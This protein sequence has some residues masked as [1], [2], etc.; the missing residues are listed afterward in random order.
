VVCKWKNRLFEPFLGRVEILGKKTQVQPLTLFGGT[1][2]WLL[3]K[4]NPRLSDTFGPPLSVSAWTC[5]FLMVWGRN[6]VLGTCL[7][8]LWAPKMEP[9]YAFGQGS[10]GGWPTKGSPRRPPKVLEVIR[11]LTAPFRTHFKTYSTGGQKRKC[12]DFLT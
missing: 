8:L 10:M 9:T 6:Q 4:G 12:V 3:Y 5:V 2:G 7:G 11:L 1:K